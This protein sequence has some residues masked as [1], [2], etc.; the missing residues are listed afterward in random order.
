MFITDEEWAK[1][2]EQRRDENFRKLS[3]EN[4][5][6]ASKQEYTYKKGRLGY[7]RLEEKVVSK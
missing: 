5:A 4:S 6:R 1:F 7:A 2:I 3:A